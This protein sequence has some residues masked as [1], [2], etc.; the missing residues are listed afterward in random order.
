M[1]NK[2]KFCDDVLI[3]LTRDGIHDN[4]CLNFGSYV[5]SIENFFF[6]PSPPLITS[7]CNCTNPHYHAGVLNQ[8]YLPSY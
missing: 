2:R 4:H 3:N 6:T 5:F 8:Y 7:T 1:L